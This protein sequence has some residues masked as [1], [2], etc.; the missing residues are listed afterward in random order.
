LFDTVVIKKDVVM[1]KLFAQIGI[2]FALVV[3]FTGISSVANAAPA[4]A[5]TSSNCRQ[6]DAG[7]G[8]V[9]YTNSGSGRY[10]AFC[11]VDYDW[12]EEVVLGYHDGTRLVAVSNQRCGGTITLF[13]RPCY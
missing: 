12:F 11:Y 6:V 8:Y 10:G 5:G 7:P 1:K 4:H 9:F 3:G 2:I 13:V